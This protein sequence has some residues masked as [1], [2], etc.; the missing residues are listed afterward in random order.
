[1]WCFIGLL[2]LGS[3]ARSQAQTAGG[4]E[5]A[6]VALEQQWLEGQKHER[7]TDLDEDAQW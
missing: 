1:M 4:T 5:K 6:V 2:S 3:A 7:G